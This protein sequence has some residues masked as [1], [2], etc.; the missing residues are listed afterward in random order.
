MS[1]NEIRQSVAASKEWKKDVK[2]F[3]GLKETLDVDM[4][5]TVV[6]DEMKEE[7]ENTYKEAVKVTKDKISE[8]LLADKNLGLFSLAENKSKSIVQYPDSFSGSL[9]ENVYK[10]IKDF[11]DAIKADQI[12]KA[13]KYTWDYEKAL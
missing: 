7:F 12:R 6:D 4:V 3:E 13:D 9:G 5:T 1:D 11:R 10:F 8:L 2:A